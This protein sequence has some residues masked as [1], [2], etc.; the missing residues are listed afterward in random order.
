[1]KPKKLPLIHQGEILREEFMK[2]RGLS[3][4]AMALTDNRLTRHLHHSYL[5]ETN[6]YRP[7][8]ISYTAAPPSNRR[9]LT[10]LAC[11]A[12]IPPS[13]TPAASLAGT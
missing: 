3:Q 2:P 8:P 1:M 4:N 9:N 13:V 7:D 12:G 11:A 6:E 10:L 5:L